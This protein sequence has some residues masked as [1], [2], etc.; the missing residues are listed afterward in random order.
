M[1]GLRFKSKNLNDRALY[2]AV[3]FHLFLT[4]LVGLLFIE[5]SKDLISFDVY[6]NPKVDALRVQPFEPK[7]APK[8]DAESK[9]AVFGLQRKSLTEMSPSADGSTV[10]VKLGNTLAKTPDQ[11]T[12]R[13]GDADSLPIPTDEYLISKMPELLE[14]VRVPYPLEAKKM[15]VQG[16]VIADLLIDDKGTVRQVIRVTGPG[17]Q[18][19]EAALDAMKRFRFRPAQVGEK[20]VAVRIRYAYKFILER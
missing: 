19:D 7:P 14:E 4:L 8:K 17:F 16:S 6:E 18:L 20:S 12:L 9:R 3:G 2:G 10:K 13:P 5:R 15:G 1:I 11:Q